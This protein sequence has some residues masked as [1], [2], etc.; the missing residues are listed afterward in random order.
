MIYFDNA[1]TSYPKP[2]ALYQEIG[3]RMKTYGANPGRSGHEFGLET[4]RAIYETREALNEIFHG[5]NPL[6]FVFTANATD[7]INLVI[8]GL[9]KKGDH[10][11]A[12]ETEHNSVLRPLE[13]AKSRGVS[14]SLV[15]VDDHGWVNPKE[16]EEEICARTKLVV[17]THASNVT[18][19]IQPI[20]RIAEIT[21]EKG[22]YF[23]VDAA[24]SAGV[25]PID[26]SKTKIDF[27]AITGHKSLYGPQGIGSLYIRDPMSLPVVKT[28]GTGSRS[29]D[30]KQPDAMPDRF[31][32]GT[33]NTPGILGLQ[34][35][36]DF[37]R[38]RGR[39]KLFAQEFALTQVLMKELNKIPGIQ[40]YGPPIGDP[41]V[42]VVSF[43]LG[44]LDSAEM[45]F[46]L[47]DQFDIITRGGLH[48][49]PLIHRRLG[50]ME[51]GAV[52]VSLGAFSTMQEID[53]FLEAIRAIQKMR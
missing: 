31:E 11:I 47:D 9:L 49:A 2:E 23:L 28:G 41:R 45:S 3:N 20:E 18:G 26:L 19:A 48:C 24:Q 29:S 25:L 34:M 53:S 22:V 21:K 16:I 35:G 14:V 1:A 50:T 40:L 39:E 15:T 12:T 46:L 44:D 32:S 43:N 7:S 36:L 52:R 4:N 8:L 6:Y 10:V 51:Q 33:V 38:S 27:L 37:V 42:P 30:L 13:L 17:C 5:E